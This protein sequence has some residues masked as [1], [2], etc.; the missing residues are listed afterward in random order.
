MPRSQRVTAGSGVFVG[1]VAAAASSGDATGADGL[2]DYRYQHQCGSMVLAAA[3]GPPVHP[4]GSR[5]SGEFGSGRGVRRSPAARLI[6]A[7][8]ETC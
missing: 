5:S 6:S 3:S 2:L 7:V 8:S 4:C 1:G